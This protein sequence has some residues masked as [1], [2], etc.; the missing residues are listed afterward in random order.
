[1]IV[2]DHVSVEAEGKRIIDDLSCQLDLGLA[3]GSGPRRIAVI[4]VN[5]SG[6]STFLRLIDGLAKPTSGTI[7]VM[8]FDPTRQAKQLHRKV[9]FVFTDPDTQIIMPTPAE[10]V[11][12][13]LRGMGLSKSESSALVDRQL[14]SFGLTPHAGTPAHSLSGGQ[15]QMLALA[16]VLVRNPELVLADEPTTMLDLPN[17]TRIE[18]LLIHDIACPLIVSTHNLRLAARCDMAVRF[19]DGHIIET[20]EPRHVIARYLADCGVADNE[21]TE[22]SL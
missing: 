4:G 3:G 14:Q 20:G 17:A 6:K 18:N 21:E 9:G 15:K 1:M 13:S 7:R 5:G 12:F 11:A 2:F 22:A 19:A 8:G 10:D 16:A